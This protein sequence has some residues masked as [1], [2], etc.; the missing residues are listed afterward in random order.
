MALYDSARPMIGG[1][2]P[3]PSGL[4]GQFVGMY[5]AYNSQSAQPV[6][7][8]RMPRTSGLFSDLVGRFAE[9]NDARVTRNALSRLSDHEL[10]DLGLT[11]GDIDVISRR[12][13]Y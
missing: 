5:A 9:W 7:S 2:A 12:P 10:D 8:G 3:R 6:A 13:R 11:R 4:F 1:R